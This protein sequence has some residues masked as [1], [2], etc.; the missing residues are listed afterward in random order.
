MMVNCSHPTARYDALCLRNYTARI[1]DEL[2][3]LPV[4]QPNLI[5]GSGDYAMRICRPTVILA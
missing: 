3:R 4:N 5:F 2:A 1:K